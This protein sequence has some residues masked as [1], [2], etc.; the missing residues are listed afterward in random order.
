VSIAIAIGA[1]CDN[2]PMVD[3]GRRKTETE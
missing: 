2:V 3:H 1:Y